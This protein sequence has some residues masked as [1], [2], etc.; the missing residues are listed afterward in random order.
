MKGQH[1]GSGSTLKTVFHV[2]KCGAL[3][4]GQ[5]VGLLG[6]SYS[7]RRVKGE[8]S[9]EQYPLVTST[10]GPGMFF[11][12]FLV[13]NSEG[14]QRGPC[15]SG[16]WFWVMLVFLLNK[17]WKQ[18]LLGYS[19]V[20][21]ISRP[22]SCVK[23]IWGGLVFLKQKRAKGQRTFERWW[24]KSWWW[25]LVGIKGKAITV[26]CLRINASEYFLSVRCVIVNIFQT[27]QM[28]H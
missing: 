24:G 6:L 25:L 7:L 15:I 27:A 11:C 21:C 2:S 28:Y 1:S 9:R 16:L 23:P 8:R 5:T 4:G 22:W 10:P 26:H 17:V 14:F 18:R 3:T 12:W 19:S 13:V 20:R